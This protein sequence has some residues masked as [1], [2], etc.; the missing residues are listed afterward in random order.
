[1]CVSNLNIL[2]SFDEVPTIPNI[3][4]LAKESEIRT[5]KQ[6]YFK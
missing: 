5:E 4:T 2:G 6:K 1:M 3:L